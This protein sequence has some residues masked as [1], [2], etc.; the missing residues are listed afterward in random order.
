[1]DRQFDL[2]KTIIEAYIDRAEP[3]GS[4]LIV[5]QYHF[6]VSSA[7]VRNQ[8]RDL[9]GQGFLE[10]PH[11][12]S[13]RIPT[14]QAYQWYVDHG[15]DPEEESALAHGRRIQELRDAVVDDDP[16]EQLKRL[17]RAIADR[18]DEAVIAAQEPGRV[19]Y[20]GMS[21]L[22]AKP[23]L[24]DPQLV[25]DCSLILDR[26]EQFLPSMMSE[27]APQHVEIRIGHNNPFCDRLST[28]MV[29]LPTDPPTVIAVWGPMRMN[30][31]RHVRLLEQIEEI[32]E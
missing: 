4:Q 18:S 11:T 22:F 32:F 14:E 10:Q 31:G 26:L 8:M 2:L 1:M 3:I 21:H 25:K 7:T 19:Y 12:S 24:L 15:L 5:E 30:Y 16:F 13:G 6:P 27:H 28:V 29:R 23:E 20:S 9:E 17:T